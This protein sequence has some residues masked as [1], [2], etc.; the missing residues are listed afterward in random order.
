MLFET[1]VAFIAASSI[2]LLIPG[3]TILTVISYASRIPRNNSKASIAILVAAVCL[4]DLSLIALSI[5]GLSTIIAAS[6]AAYN[7]IKVIGGLYLLYLGL[8]ML[9][10]AFNKQRNCAP[11]NFNSKAKETHRAKHIALKKHKMFLNTYLVTVLNP[12]GILFFGAFLPQFVT[13]NSNLN[14]QLLILS[15]TFACLAAI[16]TLAYSLSARTTSRLVKSSRIKTFTEYIAAT[17]LIGASLFT[18]TSKNT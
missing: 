7:L 1:W 17:S 6:S 14:T 10:S 8:G 15:I 16:N 18:L 3:P 5:I 9:K 2:M 13:P 12:K 4:G 11:A